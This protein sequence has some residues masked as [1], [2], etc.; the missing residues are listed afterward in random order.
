MQRKKYN[1]DLLPWV[2][3][4]LLPLEIEESTC[5]KNGEVKIGSKIEGMQGKK[6]DGESEKLKKKTWNKMN[7]GVSF[8]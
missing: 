4:G 7:G 1:E 2:W 8:K 3:G 6:G 5:E